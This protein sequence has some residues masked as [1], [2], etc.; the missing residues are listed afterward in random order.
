MTITTTHEP[1]TDLGFLL[2]KNPGRHHS[3]ELSF[4]RAHVFYTEASAERCTVAVIVEVDPVDLVRHHRGPTGGESS[5]GQYV[6]DRPYAASSHLCAAINKIFST[7][8][9]GRCKEHPE[10]V[11]TAVDFEVWF[12]TMPV[13][14]DDDLLTRL[15]APLGYDVVVQPIALDDEFPEWGRSRYCDVRL[16]TTTQLKTLLEHLVVLIPVLDD[17]KHYWVGPDEIDRLLRRGGRWLAIHPESELITRRYLRHD[18]V[19]TSQALERLFG[20]DD[21]AEVEGNDDP[22][23]GEFERPLSLNQQRIDAVTAV[24]KDSGARRVLDLGCGSAKLIQSLLS[25]TSAEKVVG[26]DVSYRSLEAGAR[27]LH[28][29]TMTPRQRDRVELLHGSLTYRDRRLGGFDAAAI[30]E[31]IEHIDPFRL[32]SFERV[33]FLHAAPRLVVVTTPN[34][35][36]NVRFE[37]IDSGRL[38]HHD[39]RFEWTRSQFETWAWGV[40]ARYAYDVTFS[41]VGPNDSSVGS[42]TQMAVFRK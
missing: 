28:V 41:G 26:I 38:R 9:S 39:H 2:H 13:R 20:V 42:P 16:S 4:G 11:D 37:G 18:R 15:F 5:L 30:I 12:P 27:R 23:E 22:L 34:A 40:A 8:M 31:V 1:A 6:N 25:E 29:D 21:F 10:L 14:G 35:E 3:V 17:S 19:M 32:T 33:V 24:I 36:Y 7:A